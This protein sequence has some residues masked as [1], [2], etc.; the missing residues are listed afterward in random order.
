[1][2]SIL[3]PMKRCRKQLNLLKSDL[4]DRFLSMICQFA[5]SQLLH[6]DAESKAAEARELVEDLIQAANGLLPDVQKRLVVSQQRGAIAKIQVLSSG[7]GNY[8]TGSALASRLTQPQSLV[9]NLFVLPTCLY[10]QN[11]PVL[12]LLRE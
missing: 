2:P 12:G 10:F 7:D 5:K 4:L 6:A 1:M 8:Q 11:R 3:S 9:G